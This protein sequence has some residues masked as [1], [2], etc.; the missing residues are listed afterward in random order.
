MLFFVI[1]GH[2]FK[3]GFNEDLRNQTVI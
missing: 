2:E 3:L 1:A